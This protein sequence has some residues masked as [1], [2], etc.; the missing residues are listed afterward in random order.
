MLD[1]KRQ[2]V[3][4]RTLQRLKTE[5]I[6]A[7]GVTSYTYPEAILADKANV[8]FILVGDSLGMTVLGY[9]TTIAVT[10]DDMIAHCRGVW[11]ANKFAFQIGDMPFM[12]YQPSDEVAIRNAGR[13]LQEGGCDA[14]KVEGNMYSRIKAI[15]DSGIIV[16]GHLGLTPQTRSLMGGYTVQG[17]T[18][19]SA[20]L[21]LEDALKLQDAGCKFMFL[22]AMPREAAALITE[23]LE[24][25]V[26]GIGAGDKVDGQL[27]IMHDLIGMFFEFK[28]KFV[29][30]Y[31][32]AG[33]MIEDALKEYADEVRT[34]K[35]PAE[36]N[37][38]NLNEGE[39][40]KLL[41]DPK[42]KYTK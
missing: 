4:I 28:S 21:I 1:Q 38:Y 26:Y 27:V 31:C 32:Q 5:G 24:I 16:M 9:K 20:K 15:A 30:R 10:M 33:M 40:E 11:R 29:K 23:N 35:F 8:D 18:L 2:K 37:F 14:V 7:V 13:F 25:P 19:D 39:L 22:E 41:A 34:R 6:P 17:K 42:W 3:S 36:E 12:S